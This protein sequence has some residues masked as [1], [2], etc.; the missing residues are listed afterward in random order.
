MTDSHPIP[1]TTAEILQATAGEL[2]SGDLQHGFARVFIDSRRTAEDGVFVAI[3]GEI[4]DGHTL[5]FDSKEFYNRYTGITP[6]NK[7][8]KYAV[9]G[10]RIKPLLHSELIVDIDSSRDLKVARAVLKASTSKS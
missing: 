3:S 9:F 8:Y 6:Y 7:D 1:W 10:K 2:V 5:I 4:H